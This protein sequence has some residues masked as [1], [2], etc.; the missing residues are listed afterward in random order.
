MQFVAVKDSART[1]I[2]AFTVVDWISAILS[3]QVRVISISTV[4][5]FVDNQMYHVSLRRPVHHSLAFFAYFLRLRIS[6][7]NTHFFQEDSYRLSERRL[8]N[9]VG[10]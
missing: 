5:D 10:C 3:H 1:V 7:R 4:N 9:E 8:S 2:I 6:M